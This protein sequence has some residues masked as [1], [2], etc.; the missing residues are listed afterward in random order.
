M[1]TQPR[2]DRSTLAMTFEQML[3]RVRIE[4]AYPTRAHAEATVRTVLAALGRQI[5]GDE[6]V[7]L[8]QCLPLQAALALTSGAPGT[9]QLTGW[10]FVKDLAARTGISPAVARWNTGAVLTA[11]ADLAGPALLARIL[12]QLPDGYALLFG[13]AQLLRSQPA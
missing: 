10:G 7:D 11:V 8:A 3:E 13:K 5:N 2:P 12:Q 4:G 6:R 1:Y 9:D